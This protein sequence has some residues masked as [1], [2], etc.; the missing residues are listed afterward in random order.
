MGL[1]MRHPSRGSFIFDTL[2]PEMVVVCVAS[3]A[4]IL[5]LLGSYQGKSALHWHSVTLNALVAIF[6]TLVRVL[7]AIAVSSAQSIQAD[8]VLQTVSTIT[9]LCTHRQCLARTLG[10]PES[11]NHDEKLVSTF[12]EHSHRFLSLTS[13]PRAL[14]AVGCWVTILALAIDPFIQQIISYEPSL[15]YRN[16]TTTNAPFA[17]KWSQGAV[18]TTD[19]TD[20]SG[21]A[22][23]PIP[24]QYI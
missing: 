2:L 22:K 11:A 6:S 14:V 12:P 10:Q 20:A 4:T 18:F 13:N 16:D 24:C 7:L 15:K 8:L 23:R 17:S 1:N 21:K 9:G 19:T 3:I 5:I